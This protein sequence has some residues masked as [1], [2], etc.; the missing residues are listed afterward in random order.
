MPWRL[1]GPVGGVAPILL[2]ELDGKE[3]WV[4]LEGAKWG[5][6]CC[7]KEEVK[8]EED[9]AAPDEDPP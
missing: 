9:E 6:G 1:R 8:D 4:G 7:A 3:D 5:W 2:P